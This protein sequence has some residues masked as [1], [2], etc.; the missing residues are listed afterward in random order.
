M[1]F[2]PSK[3][4]SGNQRSKLLS[5]AAQRRRARVRGLLPS[6]YCSTAV[7][8]GSFIFF[9]SLP[10]KGGSYL[11]PAARSHLGLVQTE[12]FV[13]IERRPCP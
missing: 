11:L 5:Q 2:S 3:S 9:R 10:C 6:V 8:C 4:V 1:H 12:E 13:S 7:V